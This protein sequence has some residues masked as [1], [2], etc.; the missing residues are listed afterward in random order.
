MAKQTRELLFI[1]STGTLI[2]ELTAD[3]DRSKLDLE[4][5][6][7]KEVEFDE[8]KGEYWYG[9]YSTGEV[10]ARIDKP[11]ITESHIRYNTNVE[12]LSKYP[13]HTQL[14][15]IIDMLAQMDIEKTEKFIELK[16]FLDLARVNYQEQKSAYASNPEAYTWVSLEEEENHIK[17][18]LNLE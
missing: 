14:N 17:N 2:G 11:V 6:E 1:K 3:N 16:E 7:T 8:E 5:F 9:D 12:V 4:K 18:K 15:I 10:R 13:I